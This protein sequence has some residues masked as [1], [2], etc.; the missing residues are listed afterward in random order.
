MRLRL[1]IV[2][3]LV[4]VSACA[5]SAA[6]GRHCRPA[7]AA[8]LASSPQARVYS[9]HGGV[10]GCSFSGG[11]SFRLGG[12]ARALRGTSVDPVV[13]AGNSAADGVSRFG[14]DTVMT[15]LVVRRLTDGKQLADFAVTRSGVVEGVESVS[16][17][18]LKGDGAVAWIGVAHSLVGH[19]E[20]IEVH[21]AD[22]SSSGDRLLDS[23]PQVAPQ[24]LR[25]HGSTITW[26]RG[27]ATRKA[28][29]R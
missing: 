20:V 2:A 21:A 1:G 10:Y 12:A 13:V 6:A 19:G 26:T 8:T 14:V 9:W 29:L 28:T 5:S 22:A 16:S 25:L 15:S 4:V 17:M 11:R 18:V 3:L 27:A 24:S 7:G 23:G